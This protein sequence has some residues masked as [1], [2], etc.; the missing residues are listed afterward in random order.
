MIPVDHHYLRGEAALNFQDSDTIYLI[1]LFFSG[2]FVLACI[3]EARTN[4]L[5]VS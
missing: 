2:L 3:T 4:H 5:T 1:E